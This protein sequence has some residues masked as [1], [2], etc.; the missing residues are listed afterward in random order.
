M[1]GAN[2]LQRVSAIPESRIRTTMTGGISLKAPPQLSGF[3][4]TRW[5]GGKARFLF[6]LSGFPNELPVPKRPASLILFFPIC[7]SSWQQ[8]T[9]TPCNSGA[10]CET[11]ITTLV[12]GRWSLA[13]SPSIVICIHS[14]YREH[15]NR[16]AAAN[17]P[18]HRLLNRF[19]KHE[20]CRHGK[21]HGCS[22]AIPPTSMRTK[23]NSVNASAS[24]LLSCRPPIQ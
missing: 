16:S 18:Q 8:E 7:V 17:R 5:S 21:Q 12:R 11:S 4:P 2:C 19:H 22:C 6:L 1:R 23:A 24:I 9:T 15:Q 14:Q 20:S 10:T 3:L 13:G